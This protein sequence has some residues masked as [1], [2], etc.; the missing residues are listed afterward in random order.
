MGNHLTR[1]TATEQRALRAAMIAA[2]LDAAGVESTVRI[3]AALHAAGERILPMAGP[4]PRDAATWGLIDAWDDEAD[5]DVELLEALAPWI[6]ALTEIMTAVGRPADEPGD[7]DR[8]T[9]IDN[10]VEAADGEMAEGRANFAEWR[11]LFLD[12]L[13][14]QGYE[15]RHR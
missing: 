9:A 7:T 6:Q 14:G 3:V 2:G 4:D 1:G 13:A 15:V 12:G 8:D 5:T 10:A 11:R